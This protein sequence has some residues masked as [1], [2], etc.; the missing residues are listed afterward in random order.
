[1][2]NPEQGSNGIPNQILDLL[3]HDDSLLSSSRFTDDYIRDLMKSNK[4]VLNPQAS[5]QKPKLS[6]YTT[7]RKPLEKTHSSERRFL[8]SKKPKE[9]KKPKRSSSFES[10]KSSGTTKMSFSRDQEFI[11]ENDNVVSP[12]YNQ[13]HRLPVMANLNTKTIGGIRPKA[14]PVPV[15]EIKEIRKE[16]LM[17]FAASGKTSGG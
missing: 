9:A 4:P 11:D 15:K 6:D 14:V 5:M 7:N 10:V 3:S 1:M 2:R 17:N 12:Q 8:I 16:F 13:P